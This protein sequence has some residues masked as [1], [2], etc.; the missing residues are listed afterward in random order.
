MPH[1]LLSRVVSSLCKFK[2]N[3]RLG[4]NAL[5]SGECGFIFRVV[6]GEQQFNLRRQYPG[7]SVCYIYIKLS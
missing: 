7:L 2:G 1:V 4:F 5:K 6:I 3:S